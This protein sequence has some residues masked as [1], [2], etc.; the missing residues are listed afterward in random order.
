MDSIKGIQLNGQIEVL[1]MEVMLPCRRQ[2]GVEKGTEMLDKIIATC[3]EMCGFVDARQDLTYIS[4]HYPDDKLE[5]ESVAFLSE[6]NSF[7]S[8]L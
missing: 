1:V 5:R 7:Q 8:Q 6:K 4:D 3:L 2:R